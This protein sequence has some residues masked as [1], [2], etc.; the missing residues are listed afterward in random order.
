[1]ELVKERKKRVREREGEIESARESK[2]ERERVTLYKFSKLGSGLSLLSNIA[3]LRTV[4]RTVSRA[5][6]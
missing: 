6:A 4:L 5:V 3:V 1:M 2:R